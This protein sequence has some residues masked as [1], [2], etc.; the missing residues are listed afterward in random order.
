MSTRAAERKAAQVAAAPPQVQP[1]PAAEVDTFAAETATFN[2]LME[3]ASQGKGTACPGA[4]TEP[5]KKGNKSQK[6]DAAST[7]EGKGDAHPSSHPG[8]TR[9]GSSAPSKKMGEMGG[10]GAPSAPDKP[11]LVDLSTTQPKP[12]ETFSAETNAVNMLVEEGAEADKKPA[13]IDT[14]FAQ[15]SATKEV[16][17]DASQQG[18]TP[19]GESQRAKSS[20]QRQQGGG[21]ATAPG[22]KHD[23]PSGLGGKH[24]RHEQAAQLVAKADAQSADV[25]GTF[26][27][28]AEKTSPDQQS[29]VAK[30]VLAAKPPPLMSNLRPEAAE[31]KPGQPAKHADPRAPTPPAKALKGNR[32]AGQA[33]S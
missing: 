29:P 28:L 31:W 19:A 2:S 22:P 8:S 20:G 30:E 10:N 7:A 27:G 5:V 21:S 33:G 9:E 13:N 24:S 3:E 26:A 17:A 11:K 14:P 32:D 6:A 16:S 15:A 23:V 1:S 12:V 18:G 4:S 25:L